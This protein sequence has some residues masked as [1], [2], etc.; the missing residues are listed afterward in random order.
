M[1]IRRK[2]SGALSI[3]ILAIIIFSSIF[4]TYVAPYDPNVQDS[5]R[6]LEGPSAEYK[7]GTDALGR[8]LLSRIIHGAKTSIVIALFATI[9][10]ML[11]GTIVGIIGGYYGGTIDYL[12]TS[13]TNIFQALPEMCFTIAIAGILGPNIKNLILA[14]SITSWAGF[15]RIIR[16]EILKVKEEPYIE[17]MICLGSSDLSI[18]LKHIIPNILP[19]II[20]LFA[21]RTGR[22]ILSVAALSFLGLGVQ[23]PTPDWSVMINDARLYYRSYPHLLIIPGFFIFITLMSINTIGDFLRDIFDVR[24]EEII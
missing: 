15:S 8:D 22:A 24:S 2:I 9:I 12:L 4:A 21:I 5:S 23:P 20:V 19:N 13:V 18:I 7:L 3:L 11:I 10:S 1:K 16:T 14:L 6:R 17:A